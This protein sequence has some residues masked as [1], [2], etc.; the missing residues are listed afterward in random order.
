MKTKHL[1]KI[2]FLFILCFS[3]LSCKEQ[4]K[5]VEGFK[6]ST[7][8]TTSYGNLYAVDNHN[9]P[10]NSNFTDR[11]KEKNQTEDIIKILDVA[12][13]KAKNYKK[14]LPKLAWFIAEDVALI[15]TIIEVDLAKNIK[16]K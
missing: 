12:D 2:L 8:I 7:N 13:Q 14:Q 4:M 9:H 3:L 6:L 16:I 10:Y 15:E 5:T 1:N 11:V